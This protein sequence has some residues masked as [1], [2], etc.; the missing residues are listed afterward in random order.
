LDLFVSGDDAL[1]RSFLKRLDAGG[2]ERLDRALRGL[3]P[4]SWFM[5]RNTR[6]RLKTE[7]YSF[8]ERKIENVDVALEGKHAALLAELNDYLEN[9]YD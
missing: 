6:D 8:P 5:I 9:Y 1:F 3:M 2:C 4:T 7:G